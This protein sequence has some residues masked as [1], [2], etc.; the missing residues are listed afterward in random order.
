MSFI[1]KNLLTNEQIVFRTQKH[2]IIFFAPV[3][4]TLAAAICYFNDNPLVQKA[5]LLFA[6]IG[7]FYW[8]TTYL[9]YITSEFAVTNLRIMMKEGVFVRHSNETRLSAIAQVSV[10][11]GIPGQILGYGTVAINVFGG[12]TDVFSGIASPI[13]FQKHA[14][15]QLT[16]L[17]NQR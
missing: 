11:Q 1:E 7:L 5:S 13:Q 17:P 3:A 2:L 6:L 9:V 8:L 4:W 15:E 16:R 14:Q 12:D 10:T